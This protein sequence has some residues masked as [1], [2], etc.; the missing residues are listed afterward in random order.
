MDRTENR[1]QPQQKDV[2]KDMVKVISRKLILQDQLLCRKENVAASNG[3]NGEMI[4][5]ESLSTNTSASSC[6]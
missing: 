2:L 6:L 3:I 1:L 4:S 5:S